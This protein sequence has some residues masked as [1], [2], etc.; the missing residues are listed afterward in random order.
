MYGLGATCYA[1]LTG[2]PPTSGDSLLEMITNVR[3]QIPEHPKKYQLSVN[4]L[5]ADV[6]MKLIEKDQD[7]RYDNP[8]ALM[9]ELLR[10]GKFNNLDAG[11]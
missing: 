1:L 10:I 4:D 8:A 3:D 5:F 9:K 2:R 11:V 7:E 6:V